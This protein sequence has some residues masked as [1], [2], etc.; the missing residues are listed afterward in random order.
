[1]KFILLEPH[2]ERVLVFSEDN[3]PTQILDID[4][5][6][7]LS[8]LI[9]NEKILY[10]TNGMI[11]S[12][13]EVLST[14]KSVAASMHCKP[15]PPKKLVLRSASK[16]YVSV[17][18]LSRE[19]VFKGKTDYRSIEALKREF[20]DNV[21]EIG[22]IKLFLEHKKL[23]IVSLEKASV[24][25]RQAQQAQQALEDAALDAILV[26]E[27]VKAQDAAEGKASNSFDDPIEID[28]EKTVIS[29]KGG[30]ETNESSLYTGD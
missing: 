21:L 13:D 10:I 1:M 19:L 5:I 15:K 7:I 16:G 27:G 2:K 28:L 20:G 14:V 4:D 6:D 17:A 25:G 8:S 22:M 24:E 26:R 9:S 12:T 3:S 11:A 18:D 29:R 23:E 30:K